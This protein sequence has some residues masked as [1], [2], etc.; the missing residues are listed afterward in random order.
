ML[1]IQNNLYQRST[2][3][4]FNNKN[5]V[6][7]NYNIAA[8]YLSEKFVGLYNLKDPNSDISKHLKKIFI[9][10]LRYNVENIDLIKVYS[11]N[12]VKSLEF[13]VNIFNNV[14]IPNKTHREK[15]EIISV[16][17]FFNKNIK[18]ILI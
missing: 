3:R 2:K 14:N 6:N 4:K 8:K 16:K 13:K 1:E 12:K 15:F 18:Y 5:L 10:F 7:K 11:K 17:K 9:H